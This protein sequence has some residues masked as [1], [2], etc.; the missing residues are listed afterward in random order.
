MG[1]KISFT[2]PGLRLGHKRAQTIADKK[3][4]RPSNVFIMVERVFYMHVIVDNYLITYS[5]S[6]LLWCVFKPQFSY[7][8][9]VVIKKYIMVFSL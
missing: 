2:C 7:H 9:F 5:I 1:Q 8:Y 4:P 6:Y 3:V